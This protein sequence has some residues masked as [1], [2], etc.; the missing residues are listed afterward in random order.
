MEESAIFFDLSF[1]LTSFTS[2]LIGQKIAFHQ[3]KQNEF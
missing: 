3:E 2:V 1:Q